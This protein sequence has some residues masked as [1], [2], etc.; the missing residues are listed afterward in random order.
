MLI[1]NVGTRTECFAPQTL[2]EEKESDEEE[3][4]E[5]SATTDCLYNSI[6]STSYLWYVCM[7]CTSCFSDCVS[8]SSTGDKVKSDAG[9]YVHDC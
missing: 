9:A 4:T 2:R 8:G 6:W 3:D 1:E 7:P 5:N